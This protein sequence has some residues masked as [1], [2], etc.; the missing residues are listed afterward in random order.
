MLGSTYIKHICN[1]DDRE[2]VAQ[3]SE[4]VYM[5]YFLGF[6]SFSDEA[7]FDPSLFVKFRNKLGLK[8]VNTLNERIVS[9]KAKYD[10]LKDLP[11]NHK[12]EDIPT[13]H[14]RQVNDLTISLTN[15]YN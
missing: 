3:I 6:T 8:A 2:A 5:Q 1:L 7:P 14:S 12:T 15:T 10:S 9:L 13:S 4:N 11:A